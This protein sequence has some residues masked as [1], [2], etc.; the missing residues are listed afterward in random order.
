M[1]GLIVWN[2][3]TLDGYFEGK[4]PW[5]LDWHPS[6]DGLEAL[7]LE[8]L[9]SAHGLVFGRRTFLRM[10]EYWKTATVVPDLDALARWN[11]QTGLVY[12]FGSSQLVHGLLEADLVD[13]LRLLEARPWQSGGVLLRY[14]PKSR[15]I[16]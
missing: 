13:E 15:R 10:A 6:N 2:L 16:R 1:A 3:M 5:D 12:V 9:H 8:Q 7:S 11:Q 14:A 4:N